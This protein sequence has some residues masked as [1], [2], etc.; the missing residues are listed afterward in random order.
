M[1]DTIRLDA[2]SEQLKLLLIALGRTRDGMPQPEVVDV[3][4]GLIEKSLDGKA[5][6]L[7][8]MA[9]G[10]P[11]GGRTVLME[12]LVNGY[13][14][15]PPEPLTLATVLHAAQLATNR[16]DLEHYFSGSH[17]DPDL[18]PMVR[19]ERDG[20][21]LAWFLKHF[22][23]LQEMMAERTGIPAS[24]MRWSHDAQ[25]LRDEK[26]IHDESDTPGPFRLP[27]ERSRWRVEI[28]D[29]RHPNA[30][31]IY[32][33]WVEVGG[34]TTSHGSPAR[35]K[36]IEVSDL[37]S[38]TVSEPADVVEQL[39]EELAAKAATTPTEGTATP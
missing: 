25:W 33:Y 29:P 15:A 6:R 8:E 14:I 4:A 39:T 9:Q 16:L 35:P 36:I 13:S 3:L 18:V 38:A 34:V 37:Y 17:T 1:T 11:M 32:E 19:G 22:G 28:A 27:K 26:D 21:R 24:W 31:P 12:K 2:T 30:E 10:A 5:G 20:E 23:R 7:Y